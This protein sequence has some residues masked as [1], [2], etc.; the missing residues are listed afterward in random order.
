MREPHSF[1]LVFQGPPRSPVWLLAGPDPMAAFLNGW[2]SSLLVAAPRTIEFA[3]FTNAQG[4]LSFSRAMPPLG[5]G[6]DGMP[7][8]LQAYALDFDFHGPIAGKLRRNGPRVLGSG[9]MLVVLDAA[10]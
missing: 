9:S 2:G 8:F 10:F 3:G 7:F 6:V 5:A 1:D 4:R